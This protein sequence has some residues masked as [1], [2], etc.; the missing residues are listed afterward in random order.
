MVISLSGGA[1][2]KASP[3]GN[4]SIVGVEVNGRWLYLPD[5]LEVRLVLLSLTL[6]VILQDIHF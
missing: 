2:V 5:L 6:A 4:L 3:D 1:R